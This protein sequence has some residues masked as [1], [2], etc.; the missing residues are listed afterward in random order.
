MNSMEC[1]VHGVTK[2]QTRLSGFHLPFLPH[3]QNLVI[4]FGTIAMVK[5]QTTSDFSVCFFFFFF[6]YCLLFTPGYN[7]ENYIVCR[8][9]VTLAD[10]NLQHFLSLKTKLDTLNGTSQ[11][12]YR[13]LSFSL[14]TCK[15]HRGCALLMPPSQGIPDISMTQYRWSLWSLHVVFVSFLYYKVTTFS[16]PNSIV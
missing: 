11:I 12:T 7:T 2:S 4:N 6:H 5:L 1:T 8:Y 9:Y 10:F 15:Y 14:D 16:F 3:F 13:P